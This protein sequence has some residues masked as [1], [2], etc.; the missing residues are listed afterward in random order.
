MD[1]LDVPTYKGLCGQLAAV[2][3]RTL[4]SR[5]RT[6]TS[7]RREYL[8]PWFATLMMLCQNR[9]SGRCERRGCHEPTA[10]AAG[11]SLDEP[12]DA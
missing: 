5:T 9:L 6:T 8:K 1:D 3:S 7:D 10:K 4:H 11:L 2:I 12:E